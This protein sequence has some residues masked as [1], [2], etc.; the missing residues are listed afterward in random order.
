[1]TFQQHLLERLDKDKVTDLLQTLSDVSQ[2]LEYQRLEDAAKRGSFRV[3][4]FGLDPG[5]EESVWEYRAEV[6][7]AKY[8]D[9]SA[10]TRGKRPT[11]YNVQ[12]APW[13]RMMQV[14]PVCYL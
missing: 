7:T 14:F 6:F 8:K 1:M 11:T 12:T 3:T 4:D 5:N 10:S 2:R 13:K 9:Y